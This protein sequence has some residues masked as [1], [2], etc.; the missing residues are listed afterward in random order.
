MDINF[1]RNRITELRIKKDVSEREMSLSLG[2]AH[3]YVQSISSGKIM[4]T[5]E[6]LL[7]ICDYLEITP[8]EFF[9][10]SAENPV[11][12][13]KVYDELVRLSDKSDLSDFLLILETLNPSDFV[14]FVSFMNR[15][16]W[17]KDHK[18]KN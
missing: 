2:K 10:P 1:V 3:N 18:N 5:I 9:Y 12:L 15:Y 11:T 16:K 7:D 4:P 8:F 6:S 13:K 17:N 14:A